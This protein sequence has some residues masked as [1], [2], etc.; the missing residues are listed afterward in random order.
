MDVKLKTPFVNVHLQTPYAK[1][2]PQ[3]NG[4]YTR[5]YLIRHCHPDYQLKDALGDEK[6]PLSEIGRKQR[7][8]LNKKLEQIKLEKIYASEFTRSK[9]TAEDFAKKHK[10]K[11]YIDKRLNEVDW[12]D[13]Y[14]VKY[15]NMSEKTRVKKI[16]QY[17][18]IEKKLNQEHISSRRLLADIYKKNKGKRVGLFCH[19]NIIRSMVTS[20]LNTDVIGFLS[21]EIY[22]SS[23][24]KLVIDRDG[25]IK[26]NYINNIWHLPHKP[27]EDLFL[28]AL[29]Q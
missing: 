26:I 9:E 23:V 18:Q 19:G 25:F 13:W 12:T 4:P 29:N 10:K 8:F 22:Q 1:S 16:R 24:T 27:D 11:I 17:K 21:M 14:K 7:K 5:I 6:M 3:I 15:F 2:L 28:A 20:I